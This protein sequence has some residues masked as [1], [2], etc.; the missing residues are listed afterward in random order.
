MGMPAMTVI[1]ETAAREALRRAGRGTVGL[2]VPGKLTPNPTTLYSGADI[3]EEMAED[4][5]EQVRL[6]FLGNDNAPA[7]V[8]VYAIPPKEEGE[9]AGKADYSEALA[10]FALHKI[11][12]LACPT[13]ETDGQAQAVADWVE[14]QRAGRNRVKA[15]LPNTAADAEGVI[16]YTT[17][18][19][20][21]GE[22]QYSAEGFC[23]RIAGLLAGTK[24]AKSATFAVLPEADACTPMSWKEAG[25]AIEAG[26]FVLYN[27]GEK[28]KAARGVNSLTTL[29]KGKGKAWKKIKVVETMDMIHDDLVLLIEDYYI[30]KYPNTYNNKCLLVSAAMDYFGSL[31]KEGLI[32]A[33]EASLDT[34]AVKEYLIEAGKATKEEA[35][36]MK[37]AD[38]KR[39]NTDEK[40]FLRASMTIVDAME[41]I[42]LRI[43][44]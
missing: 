27:D 21:V 34:A 28:V 12:Y 25:E 10:Y 13:V 6:A 41:D 1:F 3:P 16:N 20:S 29:P 31:E 4:I 18:S 15:V 33:W 44:V 17:E 9:A 7:K 11:C 37:E 19:V 30:G 40:V 23:A 2:I 43:A 32:E 5:R 38:L 22:K 8:V 36:A 42:T 14:E 39:A 24:A 35:N 26:K